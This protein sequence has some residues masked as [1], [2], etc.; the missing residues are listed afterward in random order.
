VNV[1]KDR[2]Y[3]L[4]P[5]SAPRRAAQTTLYIMADGLARL[6]AP[7]LPVTADELWSHIPGRRDDSVHL[8]LF[9]DRLDAMIDAAL[10]ERW[11]RL[12]RLRDAVNVEIEKLRQAKVVGKSEEVKVEL[13]A[14]GELAALVERYA[15]DL[16]MVFMTSQVT[17][18]ASPDAEQGVVHEESKESWATI[19]VARADGERCERC[20]RYVPSLSREPQPGLCE[21]CQAALAESRA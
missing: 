13:R 7:I 18:G 17:V 9:P 20:W 14:D 12:M 15:D 19:A 4:A 11:Q 21:R 1:S 5:K 10:A 16:P 6:I 8:A 2:L 3:T